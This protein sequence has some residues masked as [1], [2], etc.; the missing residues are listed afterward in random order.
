MGLFVPGQDQALADEARIVRI[1]AESI[2][3]E[4]LRIEPNDIWVIPGT[5]IIWNNWANSEISIKFKNG[6][7][8]SEATEAAIGFKY[9]LEGKC[10]V[11]EQY[12]PFGGTVSM[13]FEKTGTYPY[14]VVAQP[15]KITAKGTV[16]VRHLTGLPW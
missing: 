2:S 16:T 13:L 5:V 4:A 7:K 11:T 14:E 1:F 6:K 9:D 15:G 8:C 3:G 12:I 10:V